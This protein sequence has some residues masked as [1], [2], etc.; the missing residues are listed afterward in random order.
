MFTDPDGRE[1]VTAI[2]IGA[3]IGA[4][5]SS[6]VYGVTTSIT[7]N[8]S[9]QGLGQAFLVGAVSGAISGG[10]GSIASS[11]FGTAITNS[12][13][14]GMFKSAVSYAA[15]SV[16]FRQKIT[17]GGIFGSLVGGG[18]AGTIPNFSGVEG[19]SFINTIAEMTH[20]TLRGGFSGAIGGG[21]GAGLNGRDVVEGIIQ[22]AFHGAIGGLVSSGLMIGT[23]GA[24][25]KPTGKTL[26][27]LQK[28]EAYFASQNEGYG[29]YAPL[30]RRGGIYSLFNKRGVTWGRNLIVP[31][32]DHDTFIHE[33]VH[34]YQQFKKGFLHFQGKGIYEQSLYS[35]GISD[36]YST[37]GMN[38]Y[39]AEYWTNIFK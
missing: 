9:W 11:L 13:G 35:F 7:N 34:Y 24:A 38:E 36:P 39:D 31:E 14:F 15:T 23:F 10:I 25:I 19:G 28:M 3:L 29:R 18:L 20:E 33:T 21:I 27:S 6:A 1:I 5:T 26:Q 37:P 32:K 22:G 4:V 8:F 2:V 16:A 12:I 17:A 30:Y